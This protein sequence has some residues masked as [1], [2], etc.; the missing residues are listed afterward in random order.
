M[1][2]DTRALL[3]SRYHDPASA[4]LDRLGDFAVT[5]NDVR[6]AIVAALVAAH[7][8]GGTE[9]RDRS[10]SLCDAA[11]ERWGSLATALGVGKSERA[12]G[13]DLAALKAITLSEAAEMIRT[14]VSS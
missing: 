7:G 9:G 3:E 8:A 4:L 5:V 14:Q 12:E 6:V 10:A 1:S 13:G 11:S 2:D